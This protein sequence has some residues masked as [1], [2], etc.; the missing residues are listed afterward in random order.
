MKKQEILLKCEDKEEKM[1]FSHIFDIFETSEQ[2][3]YPIFSDFLD[4][5]EQA[6]LKALFSFLKDEIMLTSKIEN[7]QRLLVSLK[8]DYYDVPTKIFKIKNV[9]I[10]P[11]SHK[12]ILGSVMNLGI[13]RQKIGDIAEKDGEYYIEV[14]EE[15]A[16]FLE[17][18]MKKVRYSPVKLESVEDRI[19]RCDNF[20]EIFLTVSS[21]RLDCIISS[22]CGLSREKAKQYIIL[23][24]VKLNYTVT[25][26]N[27]SPI[28]LGDVIS[29]KRYGRF[30]F[31]NESGMSKKDKHKIIIKKY[32]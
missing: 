29:I 2:K 25:V 3:N 28:N 20:E 17:E 16:D 4:Q 30:I 9:G 32:I 11:F 22:L 10:E 13:K 26:D 1:L 21:L 31:E 19:E 5:K 6:R 8:F 15:V 23:G 7:S 18:N 12:D 14:K 27:K 24:N